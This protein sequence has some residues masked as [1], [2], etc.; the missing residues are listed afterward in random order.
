MQCDDA[1]YIKKCLKNKA[2][3]ISP[4]RQR[5]AGIGGCM[6]NSIKMRV[7]KQLNRNGAK[8]AVISV[9]ENTTKVTSEIFKTDGYS[10]FALRD[11]D[12]NNCLVNIPENLTTNRATFAVKD[13]AELCALI[14]KIKKLYSTV[15]N[16]SKS[17][18]GDEEF[19]VEF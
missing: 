12:E 4:D 10:Y 15:I 17:W 6:M 11:L 8:I 5:Q 13:D 19:M 14:E 1:I 3:S 7:E 2:N 9:V 18:E 16:N